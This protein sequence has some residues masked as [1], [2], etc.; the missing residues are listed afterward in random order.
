M[1]L[2]VSGKFSILFYLESKSADFDT[3]EACFC[4][5]FQV[6]IWDLWDLNFSLFEALGYQRRRR[7]LLNHKCLRWVLGLILM[8][9]LFKSFDFDVILLF[10]ES[11]KSYWR[12]FCW[13]SIIFV[14][15]CYKPCKQAL[16]WVLHCVVFL[17]K[18]LN[19]DVIFD[20]PLLGYTRSC[21]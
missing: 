7:N 13:F 20:L 6:T 15:R 1:L 21:V 3:I 16:L 17:L 11:T 10:S 12:F 9:F 19:F 18:G 5:C 4:Y 8:W 14:Y 2:R